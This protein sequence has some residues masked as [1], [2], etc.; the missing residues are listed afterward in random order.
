MTI[1]FFISC[2]SVS[3]RHTIVE[4][5]D[6]II[7]RVLFLHCNIRLALNARD[8]HSSISPVLSST[9]IKNPIC[10]MPPQNAIATPE[11]CKPRIW[12]VPCC[13]LLLLYDNAIA[14]RLDSRICR[15]AWVAQKMRNPYAVL[16]FLSP[17]QSAEKG[18]VV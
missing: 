10:T 16:A 1:H 15:K 9:S 14:P 2:H 13:I 6:N 4:G 8:C 18:L 11:K 12:P 3:T 17:L 5:F 7:E